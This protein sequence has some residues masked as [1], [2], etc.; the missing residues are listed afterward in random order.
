MVVCG[1]GKEGSPWRTGQLYACGH[2]RSHAEAPANPAVPMSG[3][4]ATTPRS[5]TIRPMPQGG[6]TWG[7]E[8]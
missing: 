1:A 5:H 3:F 8:A 2:M 6:P 7:A 4:L